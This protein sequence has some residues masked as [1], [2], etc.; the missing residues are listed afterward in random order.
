MD[1]LENLPEEIYDEILKNFTTNE[2]LDVL[3]L[4]SQR[5]YEVI[6]KSSV[7][8]ENVKLNLKSRRKTDFNERIE[9][10]KWMSRKSSRKYINI[11]S[12][13]LIDSLVSNEFWNFLQ[14]PS[15]NHLVNL[16]I[17]SMKIDF[18]VT[19]DVLLNKLESLKVMFIP[20]EIVNR[21]I[22][23]SYNLRKLILWNETPLSYDDL[24]YTPTR[25]TIEA[26][27]KCIESNEKL[28]ELEIQG[29]ANFYAFF[30]EDISDFVKCKL[31]KLTVKIEMAP[32]RLTEDQENNFLKFL[33]NQKQSLE[34]VY[35]D[36]CSPRVMQYIFN[37]MPTVSFIRFD[38]EKNFDMKELNLSINEKI[39][40]FELAYLKLFDDLKIY[41]EL[42][43][44]VKEILISN[45]NPRLMQYACNELIHLESLIYR[46][47]DSAGGCENVYEN[48]KSENPELKNTKIK[49]S[50][51]N[52]FL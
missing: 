6:G 15:S 8:M 27:R 52:D 29:R 48:L 43:P 2:L 23:S 41:L 9:T 39:T 46:Y 14:S 49:L 40:N 31:K 47:D 22:G 42:V 30:Y 34:F 19:E 10:L 20:R 45:M 51:C 16:N 32:E 28:E 11:Q 36:K 21:L 5:W 13:C 7:C 44:N 50:I 35:V 17:R 24:D 33:E 1:P 37:S 25:Q 26:T 4:V 38:I 3:S 18:E 12:N